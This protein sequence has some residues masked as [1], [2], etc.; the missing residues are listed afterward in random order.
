MQP[1]RFEIGKSKNKVY[2]C[3]KSLY[4]LKHASSA[5][6]Q[7]I[8]NI[9][10]SINFKRC[11]F[12]ASIGIRMEGKQLVMI[13]YVDDR[14]LIYVSMKSALAKDKYLKT[15]FRMTNLGILHY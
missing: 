10:Q 12:D 1:L 7:R 5:W 8:G 14:I 11:A 6:N 13:I 2:K 3:N 9:L 15:E 4:G